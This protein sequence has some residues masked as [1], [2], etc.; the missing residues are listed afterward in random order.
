MKGMG[1]QGKNLNASRVGAGKTMV[2]NV[3]TVGK[4]N[5]APLRPAP[6]YNTPKSFGKYIKK[7]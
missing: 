1:Y 4:L 3:V 7:K 2:R 5:S 6:K